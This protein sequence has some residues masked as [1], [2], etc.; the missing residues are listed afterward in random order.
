MPQKLLVLLLLFSPINV[1]VAKNELPRFRG[2]LTTDEIFF[3][4]TICHN[5]YIFKFKQSHV[6]LP[7]LT[8]FEA[9]EKAFIV[10]LNTWLSIKAG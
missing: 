8:V 10:H 5:S 6:I 3:E 1:V 9:Q 2:F 7:S 4:K